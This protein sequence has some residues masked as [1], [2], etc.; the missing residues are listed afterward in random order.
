M[1]KMLKMGRGG[2]LNLNNV[3]YIG[4]QEDGGGVVNFIK[5]TAAGETQLLLDKNNM[6]YINA[7]LKE[8]DP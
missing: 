4:Q 7:Y 8:I 1:K 3:A 5:K 6:E 2:W